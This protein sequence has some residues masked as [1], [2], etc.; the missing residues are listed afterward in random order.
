MTFPASNYTFEAKP[1]TVFLAMVQTANT[2]QMDSFDMTVGQQTNRGMLYFVPTQNT[3][4]ASSN[5]NRDNHLAG[6]DQVSG[7]NHVGVNGFLKS[8]DK[9]I[10]NLPYVVYCP[11]N[12]GQE[13]ACT[14]DIDLPEPI[15]G[16]R[17]NET[18]MFV[19]GMPYGK[20]TTNDSAEI[21]LEFLCEE[22]EICS[23]QTVEEG[24]EESSGSNVATLDGVQVEID[25]TGR[26]NDL[27]RRVKA[28]LQSSG[29][30]DLSIMGPLELLG[31]NNNS[32]PLLNKNYSPIC[33]WNFPNRG[34]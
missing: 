31:T 29:A 7:T 8:N 24:S 19:V 14:V 22:G 30:Y 5:G 10:R 23:K 34:C 16:G 20:S 27:Y 33:E 21:S 13:F 26:A 3:S 32:N 9:T 18:F 11:E 2:F 4:V 12:S 1:P 17:S 15:G 28:R 6:Y 25:S